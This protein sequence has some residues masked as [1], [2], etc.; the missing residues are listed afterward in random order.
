MR[1]LI[2]GITGGSGSG[3]TSFIRQLRKQFA[4]EE[5]CLISQDDYYLPREMQ[6]VDAKGIINFDL[7]TSIDAEAFTRDV[8]KLIKGEK[9]TREEY[10]FNNSDATPRLLSFHPAPILLVEGL[11]VF[12]YEPMCQLLDLKLFLHAKENLKVI[13]RIKRDRVER[14]YPLDDVLYRYENHVLPTFEKYIKPYMEDADIV[15]NNNRKFDMGLEVVT[16]FL[17]HHLEQH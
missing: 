5:I 11:F 4:P 14:N 16:G 7:P 6:L 2:I 9:V 13:R 15:I 12:Y 17:K 8:Q 3:K 1:S 10:T